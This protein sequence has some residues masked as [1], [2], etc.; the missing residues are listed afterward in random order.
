M[1]LDEVTE[2][3]QSKAD[4]AEKYDL[5]AKMLKKRMYGIHVMAIEIKNKIDGR[6]ELTVASSLSD[7][8][9]TVKTVYYNDDL[10][11]R[12]KENINVGGN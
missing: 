10:T 9:Y 5:A 11:P 3:F 1:T 12:D 8:I 2:L 7:V 4:L 6:A